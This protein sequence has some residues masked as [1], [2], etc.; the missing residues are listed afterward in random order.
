MRTR[1]PI[2]LPN[3]LPAHGATVGDVRLYQFISDY[4]E[5]GFE[6]RPG[7][8][9]IDVGANVGLFSLEV[10]QRCGGD[11]ELYAFEPA[12]ATFAHLRR[13]IGDLFPDAGA[14]LFPC[15]LAARSGDATFY[16]RPRAP[17]LSSLHS[18]SQV[19]WPAHVDALLRP[20]V[21]EEFANVLP[22][23]FRRLPRAFTRP[24]LIAAMRWMSRK[25][26][27]TSCSVITLSE[28]LRLHEVE[29]VDLLKID[30]EGA[31]LDVLHGIDLEDWPRIRAI[32]V[33]VHDIEQRLSVIR[34]LL[35]R[36]GFDRID[37]SQEWIFEGTD[38]YMQT[39]SRGP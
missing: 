33:E 22:P 28:I 37:A 18:T 25:V 17:V 32:A 26:V 10:L 5:A 39:A 29:T 16:F 15:A 12:P 38:V 8:T 23:W 31:E 3:G 34:S 19:D 11:V 1:G 36:A 7:M 35:E 13:N 20:V 14:R 21:P 2:V 6:L 4:F 30:V 9:V 27:A 24:L